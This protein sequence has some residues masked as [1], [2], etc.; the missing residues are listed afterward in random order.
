MQC[1]LDMLAELREASIVLGRFYDDSICDARYPPQTQDFEFKNSTL[2]HA[3]G[4]TSEQGRR[5]P[6]TTDPSND[7]QRTCS[8]GPSSKGPRSSVSSCLA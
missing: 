1:K 8:L 2:P 4:D 5:L 7:K 6:E 3:N